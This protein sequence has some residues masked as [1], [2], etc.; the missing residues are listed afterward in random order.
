MLNFKMVLLK[1]RISKITKNI[2]CISAQHVC[3]DSGKIYVCI[4]GVQSITMLLKLFVNRNS[5]VG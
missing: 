1:L 2:I 5:F 4:T 3:L